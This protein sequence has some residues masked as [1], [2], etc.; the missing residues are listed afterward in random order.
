M[1]VRFVVGVVVVA[2]ILSVA[3][4]SFVVQDE[5]AVSARAGWFPDALEPGS[6]IDMDVDVSASPVLTR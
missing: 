2:L 6:P 5:P 3:E 4:L 1:N